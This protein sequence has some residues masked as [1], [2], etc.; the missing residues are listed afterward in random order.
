MSVSANPRVVPLAPIDNESFLR[1]VFGD[2]WGEALVAYFGGDPA[3][4]ADWRVYPAASVIRVMTPHLNNYWDVSLPQPGGGRTGKDFEAIYAIVVDDYGVKVDPDKV[5]D[6]LG[7]AP[8]YIIETS[9]GNYHAGWFIEPLSDRAWVWGLLRG[10][11]RALGNHGDNLVKPTTLVRLPVGVNGKAALGQSGWRVRLIHW[12]PDTRIKHI[13]WIDIEARIGAVVPVDPKLDLDNSMPDPAEIEEDVVLKVLRSRGMVLDLGRPMTFG[14]GFEI[15]CPWA[16]DHT[17]PRTSAGYVPVKERFKCHHGHCEDR[18]MGDLRAWADAVI[19]EDSGGLE[20]L[21]ALEFEDGPAGLYISRSMAGDKTAVGR[22]PGVIRG[23][24][25]RADPGLRRPPQ[26][27][28]AVRPRQG[29]MVPLGRGFLAPGRDPA[30]FRL[31]PRPGS[32]VSTFAD[33]CH[34]GPNPGMGQDRRRPGRRAGGSSR[35]ASGDGRLVLGP[36]PLADRGARLRRWTSAP[37]PLSYRRPGTSDHQAAPGG[38]GR[39]ANP[40]VGPIPMG[41]HRRGPRGHRV[42]PGMVRVL[43]HG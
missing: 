2:R 27:R 26:E 13:D 24:R 34:A 12:Q 18:N 36:G 38:P 22:D 17:D 35:Q 8:S 4:S 5:Q 9:P 6:L 32:G 30:C 39:K 28:A 1:A 7:C 19:R 20:C 33:G 29:R 11:Y 23:D 40:A 43:P 41:Q 10:L 25:G 21:A 37:G 14:W 3:R 42:S 16:G 15:Q 31:V